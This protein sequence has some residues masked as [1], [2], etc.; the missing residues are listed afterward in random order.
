MSA[1]S[2]TDPIIDNDDGKDIVYPPKKPDPNVDFKKYT[3][4]NAGDDGVNSYRIPSIV[5]A[6]DGSVLVFAEARK[7]SWRDKS[8]TDIVL[9]RSVDGGKNWSAMK[10][11][12]NG[13]SGAFM[14]PTPIV[15]NKT[16][17]IFLF[18]TFWPTH[19]HSAM[20][21]KAYV[22]TSDD[23][24][25]S[26]SAPIDITADLIPNGYFINGFGP[27]SGLQMKGDEYKDRLILPARILNGSNSQIRNYTLYS[28]D[29]GDSWKM[30]KAADTGGEFQI[31][32]SPKDVLI[33][34]ART[35][36]ARRV[37]RSFD[38]GITWGA[39]HIDSSL[40]GVSKGCQSSVLGSGNT[41]YYSGI[42]GIPETNYYDERAGLLLFK[43]VNGG[44]SW[45]TK[46]HLYDKAA[47]YSGLTM[48]NNNS[49]LGIIFETA[50]SDGFT[51]QSISGTQKRPAGWMRL[52]IIV[53][54]INNI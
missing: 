35:A 29:A 26:W 49:Q 33:Y 15:D 31:A 42:E 7:D 32:E 3:V 20:S 27:G 2:S 19:D 43:S 17:R 11:L 1:C 23:N 50:D 4:F 30:G 44:E 39:S 16:G 6:N 8:R 46:L 18:T 25:V 9:K 51:R 22:I 12:T 36:G 21:N 38:G 45:P 37:A 5:T 47:G 40:P 34:N 14:D 13:A 54:P 52:D 28:D 24:G 53:I 48:I 41:L 10:Y